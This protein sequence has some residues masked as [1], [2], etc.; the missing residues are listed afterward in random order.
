MDFGA[1]EIEIAT[2]LATKIIEDDLVIA[3]IPEDET[4]IKPDYGKRNV[5]VAFAEES[6]DADGNLGPVEQN[7][8]ITFSCLLQGKKIRGAN[9]LHNL[10]EKVKDT[11]TGFRPT[12]CRQLT[13]A[14]HKF[15]NNE[16]KIFE[17]VVN[18][19]TQGT[20]VQI[21]SEEESGPNFKKATYIDQ[22][23]N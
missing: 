20:R 2:Y 12:D 19:K 13:Y 21:I 4:E 22:T 6:P 7:T 9:G 11:L 3:P 8:D 15:V 23:E 5:F 1:I 10:A 17:Y 16:A 14:G 18:F